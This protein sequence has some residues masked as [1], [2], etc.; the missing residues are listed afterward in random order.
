MLHTVYIAIGTM[1]RPHVACRARIC[2]LKPLLRG[3]GRYYCPQAAHARMRMRMLLGGEVLTGRADSDERGGGHDG[4]GPGRTAGC[5]FLLFVCGEGGVGG[6]CACVSIRVTETGKRG[7]GGGI[8]EGDM[9]LGQRWLHGA[10]GAA[11]P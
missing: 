8:G 1:M 10:R 4:S 2:C 6:E 7:R 3:P 11:E 9:L 5:L